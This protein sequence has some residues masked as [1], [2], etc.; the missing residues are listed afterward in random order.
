MFDF[1][2]NL[3]P[4]KARSIEDFVAAASEGGCR[5]VT[6]EPYIQAKHSSK[7]TP[8]GTIA[9]FQYMME[10][11]ATTPRG[12]R[13]IYKECLFERFG[14][15]GGFADAEERMNAAIELYLR[16]ERKLKE[17]SQQLPGAEL[18]LIGPNNKP[19]DAAMF[20]KLHHDATECGIHI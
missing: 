17:L 19:M 14:S 2:R 5:T 13:I 16:A 6:A 20:D 1:I 11:T 7:L 4:Y 10:L 12:R 9:D 3:F 18:N 15:S 8:V